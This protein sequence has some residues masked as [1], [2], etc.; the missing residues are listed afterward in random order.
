M[1]IRKFFVIIVAIFQFVPIV[2]KTIYDTKDSNLKSLFNKGGTKYVLRNVH[3]FS[4]TLCLP[5][6]CELF[7]DGGQLSGPIVF[8]KTRLSG[9]VNL[10]GSSIHGKLRNKVFD[11]SWLCW[12]DGVSDD[13]ENIN[14]I[15]R[16]SKNVFFPKG[17]YLLKSPFMQ[18]SEN[19]FHIGINKDNVVLQGE[20]GSVLVTYEKLGILCVFSR[21]K[22]IEHSTKNVRIEKLTF[23]TKN[24]NTSFL[25]WT[26]AIQMKG[27]NGFLMRN[28]VIKDFWGDGICLNHY[29]DTPETGERTRN[30]NINII[31]NT[32]IGGK[33]HNNRNGISVINGKNVLIKGNTIKDT[34]R[35]DMPGAIDVE[36]NNIAYTIENI[37]IINNLIEGCN[38]TA[39]GICIHA[40]D[41]GGPAHRIRIERNTIRNC[42]SGLAFV[43]KGQGTTDNYIIKDN[44]VD[45]NTLPYQFVGEGNSK[46]WTFSGN[47]FKRACIQNIP[48]KIKV[49]NLVVKNNKKKD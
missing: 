49:E 24:D 33:H 43:V 41:K 39:G 3:H 16:V 2:S 1:Y 14:N 15:I 34:S 17:E 48:G 22:D 38:G 25:Q 44:Y 26:H 6:C 10:R 42:T 7:F 32:I 5:P 47:T 29:G 40:N 20:I 18:T 45:E 12:M 46:N 30:Q 19:N 21:P 13:A 31:N 37:R 35:K 36:P 27:V 9:N 11:A 23:I 8:D 4:D 28:C